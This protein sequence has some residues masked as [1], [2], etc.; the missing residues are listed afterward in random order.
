[1]TTRAAKNVILYN[2]PDVRKLDY[3]LFLFEE[4][5]QFDSHRELQTDI[6]DVFDSRFGSF[7]SLRRRFLIS[8]SY[9]VFLWDR[10]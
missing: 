5:K 1:M 8:E 9:C 2:I 4:Q 3:L 10:D 6:D 7:P